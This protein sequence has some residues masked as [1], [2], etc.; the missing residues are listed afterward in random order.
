MPLDITPGE[1]LAIKIA[2][3]EARER[4]TAEKAA[5]PRHTLETITYGP[6]GSTTYTFS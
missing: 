1:E 4:Q 3:E 5:G 2:D 6:D